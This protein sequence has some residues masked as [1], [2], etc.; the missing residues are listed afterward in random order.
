MPNVPYIWHMAY[1]RP[2]ANALSISIRACK[3]Y[4][5][6]DVS[7][8]IIKVCIIWYCNCKKINNCAIVA[9]Y[10]YDTTVA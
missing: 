9:S 3:L 4:M 7:I 8:K 2:T 5:L 1:G 6:E 10:L